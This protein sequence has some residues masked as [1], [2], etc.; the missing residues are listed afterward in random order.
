M[1]QK[2]IKEKGK[3]FKNKINNWAHYFD[4]S[5]DVPLTNSG[6]VLNSR[7]CSASLE[8]RWR[9][10]REKTVSLAT[11]SIQRAAAPGHRVL[12]SCPF[13]RWIPLFIIIYFS[14]AS[15]RLLL[16]VSSYRIQSRRN[17]ETP[18]R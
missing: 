9:K 3:L 16:W 7:S 12:F 17:Y 1:A 4:R 15:L 5:R 18:L 11:S 6:N 10:K 8:M 13:K 2:G 14:R